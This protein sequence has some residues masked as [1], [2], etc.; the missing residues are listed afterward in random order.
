MKLQFVV[1]KI[2]N[3]YNILITNRKERQKM[4]K[5]IETIKETSKFEITIEYLHND[6]FV[7]KDWNKK[8]GNCTASIYLNK[9]DLKTIFKLTI[10]N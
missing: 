1:E 2:L 8:T 5:L 10:N 9:S 7:I 6:I 3:N 4:K